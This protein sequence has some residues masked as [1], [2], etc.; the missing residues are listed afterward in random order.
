MNTTTR[1]APQ[2]AA[3]TRLSA[4]ALASLLTLTMLLSV[5]ALATADGAAPQLAQATQHRA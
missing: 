5:N 4:I 3:T 1:T 2:A